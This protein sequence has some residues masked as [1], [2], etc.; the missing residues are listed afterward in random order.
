PAGGGFGGGGEARV[1]GAQLR[2][3]ISGWLAQADADERAQHQGGRRSGRARA[4]RDRRRDVHAGAGQE[5]A[6]TRTGE[7]QAWRDQ[8]A[9]PRYIPE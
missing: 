6:D 7:R 1:Q 5:D 8:G 9:H 4:Y 2:G 3:Y